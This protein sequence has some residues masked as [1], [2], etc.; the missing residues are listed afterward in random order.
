MHLYTPLESGK[1]T[2]KGAAEVIRKAIESNE[3]VNIILATGKK[4]PK[5]L[6]HGKN[7]RVLRTLASFTVYAIGM[8]RGI[9]AR[10]TN[11]R[12]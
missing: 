8:R 4:T 6:K 2:G 10:L 12:N 3:T 1:A 9:C 5:E 7:K 11:N